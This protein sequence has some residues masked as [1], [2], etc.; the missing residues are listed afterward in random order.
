MDFSQFGA[1]ADTIR[2]SATASC[3]VTAMPDTR[4]PLTG[5][6]CSTGSLTT[7]IPLPAEESR[8]Q[9]ISDWIDG[10]SVAPPPPPSVIKDDGLLVSQED[11]K[12]WAFRPPV[13]VDLP[14]VK[15]ESRVQT[16][17]D[18]FVLSKLEDKQLTYSDPADQR[19]RVRRAAIDLLGLNHHRPTFARHGL[20]ERLTGVYE[21]RIVKEIPG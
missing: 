1:D 18:A 3:P 10:G 15:A 21:P 8:Q 12:W 17:I 6:V 13:A 5:R 9:V 2:P 19:T 16:L 4:L 14:D 20:E 7:L 11:R